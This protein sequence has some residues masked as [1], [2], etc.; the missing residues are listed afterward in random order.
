MTISSRP[1]VKRDRPLSDYVPRADNQRYEPLALNNESVY[2]LASHYLTI[3]EIGETFK[4]RPETILA[5]YGAAFHA[6]KTDAVMKPRMLKRDC[7]VLLQ[8][9]IDE[10]KGL[11]DGGTPLLP[12]EATEVRKVF[13]AMV[14]A[15]N[16]C[17]LLKTSSSLNANL[18]LL[19]DEEL[20]SKLA[21]A[22]FIKKA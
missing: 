21:E 4:T 6:G 14:K 11:V 17:S 8:G 1:K 5:N 18:S 10:Y 22:G 20:L 2:M 9:F 12:A 16:T 3:D 13:E 19:T 7:A 15:E